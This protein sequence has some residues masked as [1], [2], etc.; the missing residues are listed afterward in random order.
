M[1]S[2]YGALT[3]RNLCKADTLDKSKTRFGRVEIDPNSLLQIKKNQNEYKKE[4]PI[5]KV[6]ALLEKICLEDL[7][8]LSQLETISTCLLEIFKFD[9]KKNALW[10]VRLLSIKFLSNICY[11][12]VATL[13]KES[14]DFVKPILKEIFQMVDRSLVYYRG[15]IKS[16]L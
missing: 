8:N 12:A 5:L 9:W 3:F 6:S 4:F 13:I 2:F 16:I 14:A 15:Q 1:R 7:K 11:V 10:E